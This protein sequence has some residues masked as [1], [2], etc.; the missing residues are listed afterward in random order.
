[1]AYTTI[2]KSTDY[3][4]TKLY[5]GTGSEQTVAGVS[6]QPDWTWLKSR[7]NGQPHMVSDAVRGGS[8]QLYPNTNGAETSYSQ[9]LKSFNSDGFVLGTDG[10]IN[11]S[12]QTYVAWNWK[13]ATYG[14]TYYSKVEGGTQSNS[15]TASAIGITAG[16]NGSNTWRVAVN[17]DSG[18]SIVKYVGTGS[19]ATVGHGLGSAPK[20]IIL[21]D[22][23]STQSWS[24]YNKNIGYGNFLSLNST[25]GSASSNSRFTADPSSSVF[26]IGNNASG[27]G[28]GNNFI[29][30]CFAEKQGYSKF[31]SYKG[32]G[33]A[34]GTFVYTGFKPA[35]ILMK[36]YTAAETWV[37]YD[38]KRLGY[39]DYNNFLSPDSSN[40]ASTGHGGNGAIDI[41][42]N[43]FKMRGTGSA[44]NNGSRSYIYMAFAEAPLVGTNGVTAK[45]R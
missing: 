19:N 34:D 27:N 36:S 40:G 10:G 6:F 3:F 26:S 8:K 14:A 20:M 7:T 30:Y 16:S 23:S 2:N 45:A 1:M 5:S 13:A 18:F 41:V 44:I 28:N 24:V 22:L 25:N 43:G 9:Y 15:D 12:G 33:N 35:F 4:N 42:S 21:K 37:M 29:A 39:N 32:N 17:R 31:G 11:A 38:N